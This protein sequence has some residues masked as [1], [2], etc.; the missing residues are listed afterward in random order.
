MVYLLFKGQSQMLHT[1]LQKCEAEAETRHL[2]FPVFLALFH[3]LILIIFCCWEGS[4]SL[5]V[6]AVGRLSPQTGGLRSCRRRDYFYKMV[7][8][9]LGLY[10]FILSP[11][12]AQGEALSIHNHG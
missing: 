5:T 12:K 3:L 4:S 11:L 6:P 2:T 7:P 9:E 1:T 8:K 10:P